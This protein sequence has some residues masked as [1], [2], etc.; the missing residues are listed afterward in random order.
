MKKSVKWVSASVLSAVLLA[1][2][3]TSALAAGA[4]V[5]ATAVE[6]ARTV[7]QTGYGTGVLTS[8]TRAE[9]TYNKESSVS[10]SGTVVIDGPVLVMKLVNYPQVAFTIKKVADKLFTYSAVLPLGSGDKGNLDLSVEAYTVYQNG[11]TAGQIHSTV[12]G[13]VSAGKVHVAYID[14]YH[15]T[16]TSFGT[17]N[18]AANTF[19]YSYTLNKVWDDGKVTSSA[20]TVHVEGTKD[21]YAVQASDPAYKD[22]AAAVT[23]STAPVPVVLKETVISG[24]QEPGYD[25]ASNLFTYAYT[26]TDINSRLKATVTAQTAQVLGTETQALNAT[27]GDNSVHTVY[28]FV[29]PVKPRFLRVDAASASYTFDW[30]SGTYTVTYQVE[31]EYSNGKTATSVRTLT[32]L[33]PGQSASFTIGQD[34]LTAQGAFNVPAAPKAVVSDV[35]VRDVT[36]LWAGNHDVSG[37]I[38]VD[39]VLTFKVNGELQTQAVST[40]INTKTD[41]YTASGTF[42]TTYHSQPVS[43][44]YS[45]T[46]TPPA[47]ETDTSHS[48]NGYPGSNGNGNG[49][50]E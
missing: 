13:P 49:H 22:G 14:R 45:V 46:V 9:L 32:G 15:V 39:F 12:A 8:E 47:P 23:V 34:G 33:T 27:Y 17:Y 5:S 24:V 16:D 28:T 25:P 3:A 6:P 30:A 36:G 11:K 40:N 21:V 42:V 35:E 37:V 20:I 29:P 43:V 4:V 18:R 41:G 48:D 2:S 44:P 7:K 50:K 1:G 38:K 31:E 26:R 19:P 10:L